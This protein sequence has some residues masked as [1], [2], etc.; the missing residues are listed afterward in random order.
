VL[1]IPIQITQ[2]LISWFLLKVKELPELEEDDQIQLLL[3]TKELELSS[4][5]IENTVA[6]IAEKNK[7]SDFLK[8]PFLVSSL[9]Q[10]LFCHYSDYKEQIKRFLDFWISDHRYKKHGIFYGSSIIN[11]ALHNIELLDP[12]QQ[13]IARKWYLKHH[14]FRSDKIAA[15]APYYLSL[16]GFD[17]LAKDALSDVLERREFN[18]SW[19]NDAQRTLRCLYALQKSGMLINYKDS[20]TLDYLVRKQSSGIF[21]DLSSKALFLK[22]LHAFNLIPKVDIIFMQEQI[23]VTGNIFISYS[24]KDA[25]TTDVISKE[26][27]K[28]GFEIWIDRESIAGGEEWTKRLTEGINN[29]Q[30]LLILLSKNSILSAYCNKEILFAMKKNKPVIAIHL[31]D[32]P[33]TDKI[34]LILGDIQRLRI[35]DYTDIPELVLEVIK[36]IK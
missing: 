10:L 24:R 8:T 19:G 23:A 3:C 28:K 34:D 14:D 15:W 5:L 18:G 7:N 35:H 32:E 36:G 6:S 26:L 17:D 13:M 29:S 22:M 9:R 30:I 20:N 12:E 2:Q 25:E 4:L 16:S 11:I 1:N 33:L 27:R 31:D 21:S